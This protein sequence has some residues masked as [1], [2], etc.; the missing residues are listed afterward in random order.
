MLFGYKWKYKTKAV[1]PA[2]ADFYTGKAQIDR[3]E[4][5]FL[6]RQAMIDHSLDRQWKKLYN[7]TV[8]IIF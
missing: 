2:E 6:A 3:E 5:E 7:K 4:E 1:H 8:G